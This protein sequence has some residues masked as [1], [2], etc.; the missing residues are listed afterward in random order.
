M[1]ETSPLDAKARKDKEWAVLRLIE[2]PDITVKLCTAVLGKNFGKDDFPYA[3]EMVTQLLLSSAAF[4]IGNPDAARDD[5]AQ[6]LAGVE[7]VL[8]AYQSVLRDKPRAAS[9]AL[10]DLLRKQK[11]GTLVEFIRDVSRD[12]R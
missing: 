6:Y 7:G 8:N 5:R 4:I 11:D 2:A 9:K 10:D 12:C 3:S 1:N